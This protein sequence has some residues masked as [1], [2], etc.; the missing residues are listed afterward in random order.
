[1]HRAVALIRTIMSFDPKSQDLVILS[2]KTK[3]FQHILP[4]NKEELEQAFAKCLMIEA[5]GKECGC[6]P[7]LTPKVETALTSMGYK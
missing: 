6:I 5:F 1:M 2:E 4:D 3:A 7:D